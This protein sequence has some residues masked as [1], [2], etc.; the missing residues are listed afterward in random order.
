MSFSD[1]LATMNAT[2]SDSFCD[3]S[4]TWVHDTGTTD[5]SVAFSE[6]PLYN[7]ED[8]IQITDYAYTAECLGSAITGMVRNHSLIIDGVTFNVLNPHVDP[9]GW[10]T[11]QLEKA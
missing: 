6:E 3:T 11:I 1:A 10:A 2:L 7:G 5:I 9:H 4:A 8:E